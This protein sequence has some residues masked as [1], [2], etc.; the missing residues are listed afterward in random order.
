[1]RISTELPR[2]ATFKVLKRQLCADGMNCDDPV[3][4]IPR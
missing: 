2:T 4:K 3:W 1:V